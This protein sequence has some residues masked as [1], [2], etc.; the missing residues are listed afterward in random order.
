MNCPICNYSLRDYNTFKFGETNNWWCWHPYSKYGIGYANYDGGYS[1]I[2][3][4]RSERP[5]L[6]MN[7]FCF[8]DE[9]RVDKLLLLI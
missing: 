4:L 7:T 2:T 6:I 5:D 1:Y 3:F 8:L 9:E